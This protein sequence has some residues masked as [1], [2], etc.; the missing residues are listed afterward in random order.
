MR[1][2]WTRVMAGDEE[3]L[4]ANMK[5]EARSGFGSRLFSKK[6][7]SKIKALVYVAFF[8]KMVRFLGWRIVV[9]NSILDLSSS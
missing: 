9:I 6:E 1:R 5:K 3:N 8:T 7:K 2:S 4:R